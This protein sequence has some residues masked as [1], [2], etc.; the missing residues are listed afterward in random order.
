MKELLASPACRGWCWMIALLVGPV[1]LH[2]ASQ[3]VRFFGLY[4]GQVWHQ[5]SAEPPALA[6]VGNPHEFK[7]F[8]LLGSTPTVSSVSLKWPNNTTRPLQKLPTSWLYYTNLPNQ[9]NLNFAAPQ[10]SYTFTIE[11]ASAG[12]KTITLGLFGDFYPVTPRLLNWV[13]AQTID[14]E[15]PFT[16]NW[17]A[18]IASFTEVQI[19]EGDRLVF[20]T[21]DMPGEAGSLVANAASAVIPARTLQPGGKYRAS[22]TAWA[23]MAANTAGYPGA[24][25]WV[26][27]TK[28]TEFW[29]RAAFPT[30]DIVSFSTFKT[31]RYGQTSPVD[32]LPDPTASYALVAAAEG[33]GPTVV[34]GASWRAQPGPARALER[35]GNTWSR[36]DRFATEALLNA[37]APNGPIEFTFDTTRNGLR[38]VPLAF[39]DTLPPAPVLQNW[40]EANTIESAKTF[41]LRWQLA[42]NFVRVRIFRGGQPVFH[43]SNLPGDGAGLPAGATSVTL[44]AGL[45]AP[46]ETC[47]VRLL[48]ARLSRTELY[49]YPRAF[50]LSG[51]AAETTA[52]LRA[53]GGTVQTPTFTRA[54]RDGAFFSLSLAGDPGRVH[55]LEG[56]ADFRTWTLLFQTNATVG[57]FQIRLPASALQNRPFLRALAY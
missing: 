27:Y 39:A 53:R 31:R 46:G 20:R 56:T 10:G 16:L 24:L 19:H 21:G 7:A 8:V 17:A 29:I 45:L 49:E 28:R 6:T 44:P 36:E 11:S 51:A 13:E 40:Y 3:D 50:G 42:G 43:A 5:E 35:A 1:L 37:A 25:G 38:T 23:R 48:A 4:N 30:N 32:V 34:K 55:A 22:I 52:I 9:P 18:N 2:G 33:T 15:K 41:A 14:T 47:E 26:A 12:S 54:A 57:E